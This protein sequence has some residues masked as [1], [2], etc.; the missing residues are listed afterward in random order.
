[1]HAHRRARWHRSTSWSETSRGGTHKPLNT[2]ITATGS[3][4]ATRLPNSSLTTSGR[5]RTTATM[6][7]WL[8]KTSI[9]SR[10]LTATLIGC[11]DS[12]PSLAAPMIW[13]DTRTDA[14][15]SDQP[16][17]PPPPRFCTRGERALPKAIRDNCAGGG[18]L[19]ESD[20]RPPHHQACT[21]PVAV[22]KSRRAA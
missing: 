17:N 8:D 13:V 9:G 7:P 1:M 4:A 3:V 22:R 20:A 6:P 15:E 12:R 14:V 18:L 16:G 5:C 2:P 19:F 10:V 11:S 21:I